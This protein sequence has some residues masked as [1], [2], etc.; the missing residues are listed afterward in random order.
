MSIQAFRPIWANRRVAI[1][2]PLFSKAMAG[3]PPRSEVGLRRRTC[4]YAGRR[5]ATTALRVLAG[6]GEPLAMLLSLRSE[7][8]K[9]PLCGARTMQSVPPAFS[10]VFA[11]ALCGTPPHPQNALDQPDFY[12]PIV[13]ESPKAGNPHGFLSR[14]RA[15]KGESACTTNRTARD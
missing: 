7:L 5:R 2:E 15:P 4:C 14:S 9:L 13:R 1:G 10:G 11:I 3:Y 6:P 12:C 8:E